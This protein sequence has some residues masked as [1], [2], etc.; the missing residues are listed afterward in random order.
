M[1][2]VQL[3]ESDVQDALTSA[4][5]SRG[6]P[7]DDD[8][9]KVTTSSGLFQLMVRLTEDAK[10]LPQV[11]DDTSNLAPGSVQGAMKMVL[12]A[13]QILD[14]ACRVTM[15]VVNVE[16]SEILETGKG[17]ASGSTKD[18]VQAAAVDALAGLP[19]LGAS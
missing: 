15:R 6:V 9:V 2:S 7:V 5:Q 3:T 11:P 12:G 13:V 8:G 19:S 16:T 10:P 4:F 18:A 1:Q 17:D 14:A